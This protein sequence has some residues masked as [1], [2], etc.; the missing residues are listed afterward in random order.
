M[1]SKYA[2]PGS[3]KEKFQMDLRRKKTELTYECC[4]QISSSDDGGCVVLSF[5]FFGHHDN[6]SRDYKHCICFLFSTYPNKSVKVLMIDDL[7]AAI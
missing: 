4:Y 5:S 6:S 3:P 7:P 1:G 2:V